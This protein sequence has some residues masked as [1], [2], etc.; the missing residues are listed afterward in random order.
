MTCQLARIS[1]IFAALISASFAW[2]EQSIALEEFAQKAM[3]NDPLLQASAYQQLAQTEQANSRLSLPDPTF[4]I[5][6]ANL[7]V[8]SFEFDQEPMTQLTIGIKQ[9]LPR[10]ATRELKNKLGKL[11]ASEQ[12]QK[13]QL[14]RAEVLRQSRLDWLSMFG[15]QRKIALLDEQKIILNTLYASKVSTYEHSAIARKSTLL[16]LQTEILMLDEQ[17]LQTRGEQLALADQ[18]QRWGPNLGGELLKKLPASGLL[19]LTSLAV[20]LIE[21]TPS[22]VEVILSQHPNLRMSDQR[23]NAADLSTE[24]AKDAYKPQFALEASYGYRDDSPLG[25]QRSDFASFAL[26]FDLPIRQSK[27][28]DHTLRVAESMRQAANFERRYLD[29][30]L[31][32]KTLALQSDA[33]QLKQRAALIQNDLLP[34]SATQILSLE[35]ESLQDATA[36]T[37]LLEAQARRNLYQLKLNDTEIALWKTTIELQFY[38]QPGVTG[39]SP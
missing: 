20:E 37:D 17:L 12:Q 3:Q 31:Q 32:S 11:L 22:Q 4:R 26:T 18:L 19:N 24:L 16:R 13:T 29:R 33:L 30:K 36:L 39:D 15:L 28:Q 27:R 2:S 9:A 8:D 34:L 14:R 25:T 23:L 1:G 10:P 21:H 6:V 7:P 38:L 5:S 35:V